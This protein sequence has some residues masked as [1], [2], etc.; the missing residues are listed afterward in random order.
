[1]VEKCINLV[2]GILLF[3]FHIMNYDYNFVVYFIIK[4]LSVDSIFQMVNS[5]PSSPFLTS[6]RQ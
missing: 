4:F 6:V 5:H 2:S 1:M 3:I